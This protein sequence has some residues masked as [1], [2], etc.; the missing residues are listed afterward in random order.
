MGLLKKLENW[1]VQGEIS[2]T[3]WEMY[4]AVRVSIQSRNQERSRLVLVTEYLSQQLWD[5]SYRVWEIF[6]QPYVALLREILETSFWYSKEC[7]RSLL[8]LGNLT[9]DTSLQACV[10]PSVGV[11][12]SSMASAMPDVLAD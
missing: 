5:T 1:P 12:G 10:G 11:G 8:R 9:N 2:V 6:L 7:L 3:L 4:T